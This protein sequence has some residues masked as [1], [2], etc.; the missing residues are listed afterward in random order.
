MLVTVGLVACNSDGRTLRPAD[1]TQTQSVYT[2]TTTTVPATIAGDAVSPA[3]DAPALAFML[4]MP[5][6]DAG[7]IDTRFSCNGANVHPQVSWLGAPA[8]AVEMALVVT[9]IDAGDFVHWIIAGLDPFNPQIGEGD[10]P[11]GAIE[12]Q[13]G[14]STA[15]KP[16]IG[17]SGP[18]PPAGTSHHYRFTL[19]ALDQQ[20]EL[21]TGSPAADLQTVIDASAIGAAQV[22]GVY[23]TP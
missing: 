2:P 3:T 6:A 10:V 19:Y 22:T 16:S 11:V 23:A 7:A 14:F 4:Q 17:W 13:N 18:C 5:F 8:A 15:A 20:V 21:P 1:P 9:D 12:G